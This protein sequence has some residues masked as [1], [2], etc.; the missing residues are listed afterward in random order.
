MTELLATPNLGTGVLEHRD[1]IDFAALRDARR[2]RVLSAMEE[3]GLDACLFG[4]EAN[5]RYVSGVRR[6]WT[7]QTRPFVPAC[8][9]VPRRRIG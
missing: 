8:A 4:R 9:V 1:R 3:H 5:A 2:R 7:A 6:L